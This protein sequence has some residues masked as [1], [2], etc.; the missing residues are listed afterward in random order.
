M[1]ILTRLKKRTEVAEGTM[2]F[3]FERP[4]GFDF[5][6]GQFM[7]LTLINPPETDD[8]GNTRS[9]S[10]ASAPYEDDLMIATRMRSTAF[11]RVLKNLAFG[12]EIQIEGPF[13]NLVLDKDSARPAVFLTGGIGITPFRSIVLQ[14]TKE[15]SPHH[16][17]MFYSNRRPEDA[18]FLDEL[19]KL[20]IENRN[21]R[22][23][24]TM[25]NAADSRLP[26]EGERGF[27]D[28]QMLSKYL[29]E[30]AGHIYYIAGPPAMV[31]AMTKLLSD[32][33]LKAAE[34]RSEEFIGY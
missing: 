15:R 7:D 5:V 8:E 6:A 4:T 3:Y 19:I 12:S 32:A 20:Q 21:F 31:N 23:V 17:S 28:K 1:S 27:V 34:I 14:S 30:L 18:A 22:L 26:W 2:A 13:G 16:L 25:T 24:T 9:F 10:I 33:G 29:G 11:K